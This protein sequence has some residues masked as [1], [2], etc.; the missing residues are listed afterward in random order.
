MAAETIIHK[1]SAGGIVYCN[2]NVLTLHITR[3]GEIVFPK[4]T[5]EPGEA[6]KDTAV[7]EVLEET[8]YH[9]KIIAPLGKL[10][11]EFSED[12]GTQYRKTVHYYLLELLNKDETPKP[13]R[14]DHETNEGMETLWLPAQE[15]AKRLTHKDSKEKLRNALQLLRLS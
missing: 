10:S 6:P 13:N 7:R 4:G 15:A 3:R 8:G 5:I 12:D 1:Q 14:E 9:V 2:G 11:Y